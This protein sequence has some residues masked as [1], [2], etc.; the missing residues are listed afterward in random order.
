MIWLAEGIER[1]SYTNFKEFFAGV[2]A[3]NQNRIEYLERR[4]AGPTGGGNRR[5]HKQQHGLGSQR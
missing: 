1:V 4:R 5:V 2:L 3:L